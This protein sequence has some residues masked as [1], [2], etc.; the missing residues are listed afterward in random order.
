MSQDRHRLLD[1]QIRRHLAPDGQIPPEWT[2]FVDAVDAAYRSADE[3]RLMLERSL[4]LSSK[5]LMEA[6][7]ELRDASQ[8]AQAATVAKSE[9]L[10]TMSHEIRTPI[11]GIVGMTGL[12]LDTELD[13]EQADFARTVQRSADSLLAIINDILDFSKIEAGGMEIERVECDLAQLVDDTIDMV[14]QM[15]EARSL[16]LCHLVRSRIPHAVMCDPA[17]LRQVLLNLLSNAIKFTH[18]GEVTLVVSRID[19][20]DGVPAQMR[21]EVRDTGIGIPAD[22][23]QRLFQPFSQVDASTTRRYGG[24]GLGLA[25]CKRLVEAMRGEMGVQSIEGKGSTFWFTLPLEIIAEQEIPLE[26][27]LSGRRILIVDDNETNRKFLRHRVEAWG[28]VADEA[29]TGHEALG[30][31]ENEPSNWDLVYLDYQMPGMDGEQ[32]VHSLL[33]S[34]SLQRLPVILL[35]SIADASLARRLTAVGLA[36][37]LTKPVKHTSLAKMTQK[38]LRPLDAE[39]LARTAI[40]PQSTA[41]T[42]I[43]ANVLVA[44]DDPANQK[45]VT[46]LL[47]KLGHSYEL[48]ENGRDAVVSHSERHFDLIL[49]DIMMPLMD[50]LEATERIRLHERTT[51]N[52]VPIVALTANTRTQDRDLCLAAGADEYCPKPVTLQSLTELITRYV[53]GKGAKVAAPAPALHQTAAHL[54]VPAAPAPAPT[55]ASAPTKPPTILIVDDNE[56][57]RIVLQKQLERRGYCCLLAADGVQALE[58]YA[59]GGIHLVLMDLRMPRLDGIGATLRMRQFTRRDTDRPTPIIGLTAGMA[60]GEQEQFE[61]AGADGVLLKPVS[62]SDLEAILDRYCPLAAAPPPASSNP[63]DELRS[64]FLSEG[65]VAATPAPAPASSAP[66]TAAPRVVLLVEGNAIG[67]RMLQRTIQTGGLECEVVDSADDA[68]AALD[69][70]AFGLV[71]LD[72]GLPCAAETVLPAIMQRGL[73]VVTLGPEAA[74]GSGALAHLAKPVNPVELQAVLQQQFASGERRESA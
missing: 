35:T 15:A 69:Q 66:A 2:A 14:S 7:V 31:L 17:R 37:Y 29:R 62:L 39:N 54:V 24:T 67:A 8:A 38:A 25:I 20:H 45:F 41:T 74:P 5:E 46:T 16:E 49:M 73:A 71:V 22:R 27:M 32:V 42:R 70:I 53:G 12:L 19:E 55:P 6:N 48:V 64:A 59:Q 58:I 57:N 72:L 34:P 30:M 68:T 26:T 60:S 33:A 51:G 28:G 52:H 1:R 10:A 47:G 13:E 50:G 21:F 4:D 43:Q 36:G 40:R 3:D 56:T 63:L 18:A 23:L 65:P 61:E 11:N 44:E 9:F